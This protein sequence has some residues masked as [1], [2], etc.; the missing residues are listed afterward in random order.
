MM[1]EYKLYN[2]VTLGKRNKSMVVL[3]EMEIS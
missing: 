2:I 3:G 1:S